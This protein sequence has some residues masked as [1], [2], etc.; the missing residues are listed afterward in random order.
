M[1]KNRSIYL[2][3]ENFFFLDDL[4]LSFSRILRYALS[5]R[6]QIIAKI[7]AFYLFINF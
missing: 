3:R 4:S 6:T 2:E 5:L 7:T 1:L